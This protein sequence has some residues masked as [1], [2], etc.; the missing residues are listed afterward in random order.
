[1]KFKTITLKPSLCDYSDVHLPVKE[2]IS[3]KNT[4]TA[5]AN[6]NNTN[7]K[8]I[9]ILNYTP[10]TNSMSEINNTQADNAKDIDVVMPNAQL[11][12]I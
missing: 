1:M 9:F 5:D 2:T 6:P 4:V 10:F 8:V 11:V 3:I 12:R 7:K